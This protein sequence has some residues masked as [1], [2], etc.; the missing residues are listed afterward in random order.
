ML[1][2]YCAAVHRDMK[3]HNIM[4]QKRK[5]KPYGYIAK[6]IDFGLSKEVNENDS[7]SLSAEHR[8]T[9]CWAPK[10]MLSRKN[11]NCV[12]SYNLIMERL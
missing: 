10:E 2:F 3:P 9:C 12:S 11:D 5:D 4:L 7:A 6:I 1:N 8:Y